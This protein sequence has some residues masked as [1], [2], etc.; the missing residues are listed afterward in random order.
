MKEREGGGGDAAAVWEFPNWEYRT[1]FSISTEKT[2]DG[3][4]IVNWPYNTNANSLCSLQLSAERPHNHHR[5]H[6]D[7]RESELL[8]IREMEFLRMKDYE[9]ATISKIQSIPSLVLP[10]TNSSSGVLMCK[11]LST[12]RRITIPGMSIEHTFILIESIIVFRSNVIYLCLPATA[13]AI[14]VAASAPMYVYFVFPFERIAHRS[15]VSPSPSPR[16]CALYVYMCVA[17]VVAAVFVCDWR[18]KRNWIEWYAAAFSPDYIALDDR[19][20]E[21]IQF[22]SIQ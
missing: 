19:D 11:N 7:L 20:R 22:H 3:K 10:H 4:N 18:N 1:H 9:S 8:G 21:L 16:H 14:A 13:G 15:R 17:A 6:V 5:K 2:I 12:S